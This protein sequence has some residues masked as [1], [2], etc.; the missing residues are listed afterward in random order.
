MQPMVQGSK[1]RY[2]LDLPGISGTTW[3]SLNW[4]MA[5]GA[6]VFKVTTTSMNWWH[7]FLTPGE[8]Y[9][10]VHTNLSNLH[11]QDVWAEAHLRDAQRI[12]GRGRL[13]AL[14]FG[15][16]DVQD[17]YH[18]QLFNRMNEPAVDVFAD[19]PLGFPPVS[20]A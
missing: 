11:D 5:S 19:F 16:Q 18:D 9:L 3:D 1:Y 7:P 13:K 8:D 17:A 10:P 2:L 12:A 6:L 15:R 4:K 20:W 14:H